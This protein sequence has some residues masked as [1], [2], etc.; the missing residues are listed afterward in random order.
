MVLTNLCGHQVHVCC[1]CYFPL[2]LEVATTLKMPIVN[3]V[4]LLS[5]TAIAGCLSHQPISH[6]GKHHNNPVSCTVD[7]GYAKYEGTTLTNGVRQYLGMRYAAPP[8][9]DLRWRA[10]RNPE[11]VRGVQSAADVGCRLQFSDVNLTYFSLGLPVQ[12][13][14]TLFLVVGVKIAFTSTYGVHRMLRA[15]QSFQFGSTSAAE[16]TL[17]TTMAITMELESLLAP[18]K[19]SSSSTSIIELQL[20]AS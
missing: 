12:E 3:A 13:Q 2:P 1:S 11:P 18:I 8:V 6:Y 17:P 5:I 4:L 9:G 16:A 19:V 20:L 10:P 14:S 7:L 15:L